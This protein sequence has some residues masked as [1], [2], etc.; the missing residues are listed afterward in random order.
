MGYQYAVSTIVSDEITVLSYLDAYRVPEN[1]LQTMFKNKRAG[2]ADRVA[3]KQSTTSDEFTSGA[4]IWNAATMASFL[5]TQINQFHLETLWIEVK[6]AMRLGKNPKMSESL[7]YFIDTEYY[8]RKGTYPM[9]LELAIFDAWGDCVFEGSIDHDKTL[10]ELMTEVPQHG[11][12]HKIARHSIWKVYGKDPITEENKLCRTTGIKMTD[13]ADKLVGLGVSPKSIF[14]EW[15]TAWSDFHCLSNNLKAI[16]KG[17][18]IP[19][20][21]RWLR[22][23]LVWR[24]NMMPGIATCA[25]ELLFPLVFPN[26]ALWSHH[27]AKVDTQKLFMM[28]EKML[29]FVK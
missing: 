18:I 24:Q 28:T 10:L 20:K 13:V 19:A 1:K 7:V 27:R 3:G 29:E 22:A 11:M 9:L 12:I 8:S 17:D 6:N 21:E 26:Q 5:A 16:K 23:P 2:K 15:S 25:L 14:V 4:E